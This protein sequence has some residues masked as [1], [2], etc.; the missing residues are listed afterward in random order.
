[1]HFQNIVNKCILQAS[2]ISKYYWAVQGKGKQC[3][4]SFRQKRRIKGL[5]LINDGNTE[6]IQY[7]STT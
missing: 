7:F 6:L 5:E 4:C 1:M 2:Y 3:D